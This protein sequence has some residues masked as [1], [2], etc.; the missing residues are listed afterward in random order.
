[1]TDK[2]PHNFELIW[3]IRLAF[4][5]ARI[6]HCRRSPIDTSLSIFFSNFQAAQD[7]AWDRGDI[8]FYYRHYERLMDHWRRV[9]PADRF[10][11]VEYE[12]LVADREAETRRLIAFI[13]LDWDRHL[14]GARA[15][16]SGGPNREPVAGATARLQHVSR[17][18]AAL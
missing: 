11:E 2:A 10:T 8:V 14:H 4:P 17:T 7:Y 3:L 6:I 13:G 15:E 16:P 9:L 18:L 5:D 1:M 12:R